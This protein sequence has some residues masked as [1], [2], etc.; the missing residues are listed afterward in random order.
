M[1]KPNYRCAAHHIVAGMSIRAKEATYHLSMHAIECYEKVNGLLRS[2]KST[3]DVLMILE[4][5][6]QKLLEGTF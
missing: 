6:R 2:A 1:E 3:E 5:I 4:V